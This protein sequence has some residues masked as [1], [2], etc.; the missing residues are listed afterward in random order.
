MIIRIFKEGAYPQGR[1]DRDRVRR[2]VDAHYPEN[3]TE[4]AN[5]GGK[6]RVIELKAKSE[7][8]LDILKGVII[9]R[10]RILLPNGEVLRVGFSQN[11][12]QRFIRTPEARRLFT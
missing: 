3:D 11:W 10:Y 8:V 12:S 1:W 6:S 9:G 5:N 4:V 7:K 2:L